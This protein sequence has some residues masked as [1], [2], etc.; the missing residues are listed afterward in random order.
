MNTMHTAL[1]EIG[2]QEATFNMLGGLS[3]TSLRRQA[4]EWA[5]VLAALTATAIL[6]VGT[7]VHPH[8]S[9]HRRHRQ[10]SGRHHVAG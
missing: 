2:W 4:G 1:F 3:R 7:L 10:H 8:R 5:A 9:Y 6:M